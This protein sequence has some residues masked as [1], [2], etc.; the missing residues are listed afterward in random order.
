MAVNSDQVPDGIGPGQ[1]GQLC[2]ELERAGVDSLLTLDSE[3]SLATGISMLAD[4]ATLQAS[5][6][7]A[8]RFRQQVFDTLANGLPMSVSVY[9]PGEG[10]DAHT[11]FS[12]VCDLLRRAAVDAG[13]TPGRIVVA[14]AMAALSPRAAWRLR[15]EH[16]GSGAVYLLPGDAIMRSDG[17]REQRQRDERF[18]SELWYARNNGNVRPACAAVVSPQSSLL[19]AERANGI[20]PATALQSPAG[21]AWLPMRVDVSRFADAGGTLRDGALEQ[22]LRCCVDIGE[23]LHEQ[24]RW[25]TA[26]LRHDAWLNRRLAIELTGFGD[27]VSRRAQDPGCFRS[28]QEISALL[29]WARTILQHQSRAVARRSGHLPAFAQTDPSRAL[30]SGQVRDGWQARWRHAVEVSAVRHRNLLVLSPWSVFPSRQPADYRFTDLLPVLEFADACAFPPWP[31]ISHWN[32]S[33]FKRFHKRTWAVLQ[34]RTD[35]HQIAE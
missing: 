17:S 22:A 6:R 35:T 24:V 27:L 11:A 34:Q 16:L 33:K 12:I 1:A 23:A 18:W 9:G 14:V 25:P 2:R 31:G 28:L 20:Q 26:Q 7:A 5:D 19:S 32:I 13:V 30:P 15:R 8:T 4:A 21:S 10:T 3:G 29:R